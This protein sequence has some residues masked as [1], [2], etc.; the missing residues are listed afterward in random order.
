MIEDEYRRNEYEEIRKDLM[1]MVNHKRGQY[2]IADIIDHMSGKGYD[3]I[4]KIIEDTLVESIFSIGKVGND[5][6]VWLKLSSEGEELWD[7]YN[8]GKEGYF[9]KEEKEEGKTNKIHW[10]C[11]L[12]G[13]QYEG[14]FKPLDKCPSC[15]Q[16]CSF[17]DATC[18]IPECQLPDERDRRI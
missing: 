2:S 3:D 18:Y 14:D 7:K 17:I 12:C 8:G 13:Y 5:G 15:Y 4:G 10:K 6:T 1:E 16:S 11:S 9:E